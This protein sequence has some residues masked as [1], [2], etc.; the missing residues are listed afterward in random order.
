MDQMR[1]NVPDDQSQMSAASR[2]GRLAGRR[3]GA[4][5]IRSLPLQAFRPTITRHPQPT[6]PLH[7]A[8]TV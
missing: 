7:I 5:D 8:I 6:H 1:N 4:G 3:D 2:R